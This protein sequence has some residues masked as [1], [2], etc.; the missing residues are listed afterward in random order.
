MYNPGYLS[1]LVLNITRRYCNILFITTVLIPDQLWMGLGLGS[2]LMVTSVSFYLCLS[3]CLR[4]TDGRRWSLASLPSSGYGTNTPSSTVS[5]RTIPYHSLCCKHL[6]IN[7]MSYYMCQL[8]KKKKAM[9]NRLL[10]LNTFT[11]SIPMENHFHPAPQKY[12]YQI[13]GNGRINLNKDVSM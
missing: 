7:S 2:K 6:R 3:V 11:Y 9:P 8:D 1:I 5:V 13:T 10:N 12:R 4:R